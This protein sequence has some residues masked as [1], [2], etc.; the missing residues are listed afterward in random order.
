MRFKQES[1]GTTDSE[2]TAEDTYSPDVMVP[3]KIAGRFLD[4]SIQGAADGTATT[5]NTTP[6]GLPDLSGIDLEVGYSGP[7]LHITEFNIFAENAPHAD[8]T[9][10]MD[11]TF[12]ERASV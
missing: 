11:E 2:E 4:N 9:F 5:E 7:A 1:G 8:G 6:V 12:L 10:K 3:F